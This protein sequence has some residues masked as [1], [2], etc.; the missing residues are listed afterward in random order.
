M[1]KHKEAPTAAWLP[2]KLP[3]TMKVG[4][5]AL[6]V[7]KIYE[8]LPTSI[9]QKKELGLKWPIMGCIRIIEANHLMKG[10]HKSATGQLLTHLN[11]W[12]AGLTY[13]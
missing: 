11:K 8:V 9:D 7:N 10:W 2:N 1:E 3:V 4:A 6:F 12:V 13:C 5:I